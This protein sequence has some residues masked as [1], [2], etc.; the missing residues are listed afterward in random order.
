MTLPPYIRTIMYRT[1]S[2]VFKVNLEELPAGTN[3]NDYKSFNQFFIRKID[4]SKRPINDHLSKDS[5]C[6]PCDG[7]I[8]SFG[9]LKRPG[10][11]VECVKG[12]DYPI[13]EFL[14]GS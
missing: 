6:S 11:T 3:L 4:M 1:Y 12:A 2:F 7:K 10:N 8:L 14:F 13:E 9:E 5:L